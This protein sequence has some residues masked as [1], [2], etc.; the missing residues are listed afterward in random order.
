MLLHLALIDTVHET[1]IR[2]RCSVRNKDQNNHH[3]SRNER[4]SCPM[5]KQEAIPHKL[6]LSRKGTNHTNQ[7]FSIDFNIT[8]STHD[9]KKKK[10]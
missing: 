2:A 9:E 8:K 7:I 10:S 6:L 5:D 4:G 3:T 1:V